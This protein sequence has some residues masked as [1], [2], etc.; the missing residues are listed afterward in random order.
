MNKV[1]ITGSS[2]G[3]GFA[4]AKKFIDN[5][6]RVI[7]HYFHE[8]NNLDYLGKVEGNECIY[9]DFRDDV[10]FEEF[11]SIIK[12]KKIDALINN[13][14]T[15]DFSKKDENRIKSIESILKVNLIAPVLLTEVVMEGMKK[16][17]YGH[18]V[19]ISSIGAKYGSNVDN[20]FYGITKRGIESAT[21]SFSR[22]GSNYNI[23]VNSIR[24][25]VTNTEFYK[26]LGKDIS[27][28]IE[29]IPLNRA[30]EPSELANYI[31]FMCI[32]NTFITNEIIT[33]S[34]GE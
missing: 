21:K 30:M 15:Y 4:C 13:A 7:A 26:T 31:Y 10:A 6:Y 11:I 22:A 2:T 17:K 9:C 29:L 34:G 28:R 16:R 18:V 27:K 33:I 1:L 12:T 5:G 32:E 8:N 14:G 25:G 24:P 20:I 3:I 23:L 19:N